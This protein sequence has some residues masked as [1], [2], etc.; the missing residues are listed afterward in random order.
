MSI[1][2]ISHNTDTYAVVIIVPL[3]CYDGVRK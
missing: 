1:V 3:V 2:Q